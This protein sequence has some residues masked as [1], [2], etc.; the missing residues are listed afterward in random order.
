M[1]MTG[2]GSPAPNLELQAENA[3]AHAQSEEYSPSFCRDGR[4]T[5]SE[6][7]LRWR[8]LAALAI[9]VHLIGVAHAE[10][11]QLFQKEAFAGDS[12]IVWS[13]YKSF[14]ASGHMDDASSVR[15]ISGCWLLCDG[16]HFSGSCMWLSREVP[17]FR[18]LAFKDGIGSLRSERI[19][20]LRRNWGGRPA[21]PRGSLVFFSDINYAGEWTRFEAS[22][23]DFGALKI[24]VKPGSIVLESGAWRICTKPNFEGWCLSMTASTWNLAEIFTTD[25]KSAE[26]LR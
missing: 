7:G 8:R 18:D 25:I 11:I 4:A 15:V 14:G 5:L 1:R 10:R 2:P 26:R 22:V 9:G 23:P 12:E 17:S 21:A 16:T 3:C 24:G 6:T 20:V 19:P 13:D